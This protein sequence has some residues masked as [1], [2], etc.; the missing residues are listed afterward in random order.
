[1]IQSSFVYSFILFVIHSLIHTFIYIELLIRTQK[2][3]LHVWSLQ[4]FSWLSELNICR[5]RIKDWGR[6]LTTPPNT[7]RTCAV[8]QIISIGRLLNLLQGRYI[9]VYDGCVCVCSCVCLCVCD[10]SVCVCKCEWVG[11]Q[12]CA[13]VCVGVCMYICTRCSLCMLVYVCVCDMCNMCVRVYACVHASVQTCTGLHR[14]IAHMHVCVCVCAG[15]RYADMLHMYECTHSRTQICFMRLY[16]AY[17]I[18]KTKMR[19]CF[20]NSKTS[21]TQSIVIWIVYN[22]RLDIY[23]IPINI[24]VFKEI[25]LIKKMY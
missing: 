21:Q 17:F 2:Y 8:R 13:S 1:M 24:S 18:H 22:V 14:C 3:S 19:Q 16:C 5:R 23:C 12:M 20:G 6:W 4:M 11:A 15:I 7:L 9:F 25:K 10:I